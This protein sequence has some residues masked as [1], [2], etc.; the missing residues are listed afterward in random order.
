MPLIPAAGPACI[1]LLV[2]FVYFRGDRGAL[3]R[4]MKDQYANFVVQTMIEKSKPRERKRLL[5]KIRP[6][7]KTL[8]KDKNGKHILKFVLKN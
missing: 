7:M 3:P 2:G 8:R 1:I 6:H 5:S 4:M